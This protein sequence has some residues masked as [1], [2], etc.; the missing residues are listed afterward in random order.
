MT[1]TIINHPPP[2]AHPYRGMTFHSLIQAAA[3]RDE[4]RLIM[5][6]VSTFVTGPVHWRSSEPGSKYDWHWTCTDSFKLAAAGGTLQM[7]Y[8]AY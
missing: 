8:E 2:T 1:P 6:I 7:L 3:S 5:R 4:W